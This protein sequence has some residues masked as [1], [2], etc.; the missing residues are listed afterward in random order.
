MGDLTRADLES[1]LARAEVAGPVWVP[2]AQK[3]YCEDVPRLIAL[4]EELAEDVL[5]AD[6][7]EHAVSH[8][9]AARER[10]VIRARALL[11]DS[12]D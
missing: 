11:E 4:V 6:G 7:T 5:A 1:M 10:R 2:T 9:T 8:S 3:R 12:N